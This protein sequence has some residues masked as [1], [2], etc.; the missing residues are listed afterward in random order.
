MCG[1]IMK[2][3]KKLWAVREKTVR[4]GKK[5][6]EKMKSKKLI[7]LLSAVAVASSAFAAFTITS[8]AAEPVW[9]YDAT[10][11]D[12]SEWVQG[13][14]SSDANKASVEKDDDGNSYIKITNAARTSEVYMELPSAA[15]LS[16]D[17]VVEFDTA[18]HPG[19]G[20]GRLAQYNQVAVLAD[21]AAL[22]SNNYGDPYA[23]EATAAHPM[24]QEAGGAGSWSSD[25]A[26][27]GVGYM[28]GVAASITARLELAGKWIVNRQDIAPALTEGDFDGPDSEWMSPRGS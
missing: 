4:K 11:S 8:S 14:T 1:K 25:T 17:Y 3:N 9:S 28:S 19:N 23:A 7:S 12:A 10:D 26:A 5:G 27:T 20:M 6:R 2:V 18:I 13:N 22:D 15:Q 16:N 21:D 24:T